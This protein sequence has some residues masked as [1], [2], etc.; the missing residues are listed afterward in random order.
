MVRLLLIFLS[1]VLPGAA[2]SQASSMA[3]I[4]IDEKSGQV[5]AELDQDRRWY[6]ASLTKM[7]TVYLA[8]EEIEAG[9]LKMDEKLTTSKEAARQIPTKLGLAPGEKITVQQAISA[10]IIR[11]A[12]DACVVL[13]EKISGS[14]DKF[15]ER[16]TETA[17]KLGMSATQFRN[18]SGLPD[19][20]Q[21]TT[22]R[23]LAI[24]ARAL[25][26]N[27]PKHYHFFDQTVLRFEGGALPTVNGFLSRYKDADG[28][29]TGFTCGSGYNLVAS[30]RRGDKRLIGVVLGGL[31]REERYT[32]MSKILNQ[33]FAEKPKLETLVTDIGIDPRDPPFQLGPAACVASGRGPGNYEASGALFVLKRGNFR[34]WGMIFGSFPTTKQATA[35]ITKMR[36][37]LKGVVSGGRAVISPINREGIK[38]YGALLTGFDRANVGKACRHLQQK[39]FYC[40]ALS[41]EMLN[42]NRALWR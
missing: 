37:E 29:K 18:A 5:L 20:D 38:K 17:K 34:G 32:R 21:F 2:W 27:F 10:A 28:L 24:L 33:G 31:N 7:M 40:L 23:D 14:E 25:I 42:N 36:G 26:Q 16:M 35:V 4:V 12:N 8:F 1:V 15:A 3:H 41:P 39:G 22:A 9:R 13:A 6:P 19:G 11:S 30:A